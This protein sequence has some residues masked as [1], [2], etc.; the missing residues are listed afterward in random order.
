MFSNPAVRD[1]FFDDKDL[2]VAMKMVSDFEFHGYY[3]DISTLDEIFGT[4]FA[5]KDRG[6]PGIT[7]NVDFYYID[8]Q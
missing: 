7:E 8:P 3:V 5:N 1:S 4:Y 6:L 2:H